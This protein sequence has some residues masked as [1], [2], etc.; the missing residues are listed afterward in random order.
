MYD[1]KVLSLELFINYDVGTHVGKIAWQ[2]CGSKEVAGAKRLLF[3]DPTKDLDRITR[4][5]G[6]RHHV[7]SFQWSSEDSPP[8][9]ADSAR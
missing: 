9:K 5:Q 8:T 7:C 6:G 1:T 4:F 2:I 3:R